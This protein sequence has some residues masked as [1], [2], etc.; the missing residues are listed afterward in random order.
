ML[1]LIAA[2]FRENMGLDWMFVA[3]MCTVAVSICVLMIVAMWTVYT[4]AGKPGWA[5]LIPFYNLWVLCEIAGRPGWWMFLMMIPMVGFIIGIIVNVGIAEKF[6]KDVAF[7]IGLIFLSFI[8]Y[9]ILA[10]GDARYRG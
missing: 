2:A 8:F 6:G 4:K 1:T 10:F 9:P 3:L 5:C 7:A